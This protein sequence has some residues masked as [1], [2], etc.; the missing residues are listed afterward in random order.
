MTGIHKCSTVA[1]Q[2]LQYYIHSYSGGANR[3]KYP[4]VLPWP[5]SRKPAT[6][7]TFSLFE[8]VR[9][10]H[11]NIQSSHRREKKSRELKT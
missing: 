4:A 11:E 8:G 6:I 3:F 5:A 10:Y 2:K 1:Y 9:H 7:P